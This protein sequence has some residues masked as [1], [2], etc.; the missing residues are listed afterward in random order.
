M[1]RRPGFPARLDTPSAPGAPRA[2]APVRAP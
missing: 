1:H 2:P